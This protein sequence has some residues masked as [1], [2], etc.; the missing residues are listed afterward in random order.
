MDSVTTSAPA[1]AILLGEHAVNRNQPAIAASVGLRMKCHARR[2]GYFYH[3]QSPGHARTFTR[4]EVTALG[5]QVDAWRQAQNYPAI[6]EL[7][8][9]DYFAPAKYIIAHALRDHE[10]LADGLDI[11]FESAIPR[12]GGLGSGGAANVALAMALAA[13][14]GLPRDISA[15]EQIGR[16]AYLGDVVAH[17]GIASALD[18]QTS[19]LGG[20]I[21]YTSSAWGEPI[22]IASGLHLVIGDTGVRGQTSEVNSRVREW[23]AAAP[24]RMRYFE[25]IGVLSEAAQHS[26]AQGDWRSLG[27]L[28]NMNQLVLEKIGVSCPEL[29]RLIEAAIGAGAFGA[30]LS[31]SG[32]GG[33]MIALTTAEAR[34]TVA[35]ALRHAGAR[36]VYAPD[37]GVD[38]ARLE[39]E[40]DDER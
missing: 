30:K 15:R 21:R 34:D 29:E 4:D 27:R 8:A 19:L 25:M 14:A 22:P 33:I 6:R 20:V 26:L 17:G 38:G 9:G 36:A 11:A 35:Q 7:A 31:G 1:K 32:G 13:I 28:M 18:T 23:L 5:A 2:G 24:T 37:V 12:S 10:I 16:W 39:P 3:L 40:M